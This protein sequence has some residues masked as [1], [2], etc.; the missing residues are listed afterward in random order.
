MKVVDRSLR[1][2]DGLASQPDGIGVTRLATLLGEPAPTVHRVL[3]VLVQ[4]SLA[5]RDAESRRYYLGPRVLA[6]GHAY[7]RSHPLVSVAQASLSMLRDATSESA[8]L[9]ELIDDSVICTAAAESNRP[10][11]F[12]ARVGQVMPLHAAASAR[13]ILAF[14]G[15]EEVDRL[16]K[17]GQSRRPAGDASFGTG[18]L[19][20][21]LAVVR[22]TGFAVCD[23]EIEP[24][25]TAVSVPIFRAPGWADASLTIVAPSHRMPHDIRPS[26]AKTLVDAARAISVSMGF[27][28]STNRGHRQGVIANEPQRGP[29][30]AALSDRS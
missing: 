14:R 3:G 28:A 21:I 24:E 25:V 12:L 19:A 6:L 8:F 16:L 1:V 10:L 17:V 20:A 7:A 4:H 18:D 27:Q 23:Q 29:G 22:R 2:L 26:V 13:A 5:R 9:A 11:R 30:F 15:S